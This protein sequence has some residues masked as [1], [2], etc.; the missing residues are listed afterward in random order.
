V[1]V[2]IDGYPGD[3]RVAL[4]AW[5]IAFTEDG[6]VDEYRGCAFVN[7]AAEYGR[8]GHPVRAMA[9]AQRRWV[10]ETTLGLLRAAGHPHPL[11][12]ARVLLAL[13]TGYVYSLGL[14]E[15]AGWAEQFLDAC[16]RVIDA[17]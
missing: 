3:S 16:D 13:R 10:N 12:A 14:E 11:A 15:D 17:R 4:H 8:P 7:A 5:A 9:V 2:I 1:Q 6:M